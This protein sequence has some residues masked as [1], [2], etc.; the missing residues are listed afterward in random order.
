MKVVNRQGAEERTWAAR[1][2]FEDGGPARSN[3]TRLGRQREV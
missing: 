2:R 3:E 1:E